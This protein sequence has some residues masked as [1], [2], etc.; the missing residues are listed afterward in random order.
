MSDKLLSGLLS[1][2]PH[3]QAFA[4]TAFTCNT[5]WPDIGIG[6]R[7]WMSVAAMGLGSVCQ[8]LLQTPYRVGFAQ[9]QGR[10]AS[11]DIL[12]MS[13][14][15]QVSRITAGAMGARLR[16]TCLCMADMIQFFVRGHRATGHFPGITMGSPCFIPV[17]LRQPLTICPIAITVQSSKPGPTSFD[18]S[19][20]ID[21]TPK[22][23]FRTQ[24]F[25]SKRRLD[26]RLS[27]FLPTLIMATTK[28][29]CDRMVR[30]ARNGTGTHM[31]L[32]LKPR[33]GYSHGN[34]VGNQGF[35]SDPSRERRA[36]DSPFFCSM[37]AA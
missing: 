35:G 21:F 9:I 18:A 29:M 2:V 34:P 6:W 30:T 10:I 20:A 5:T 11:G 33:D 1:P 3:L 7:Q 12:C 26:K 4:Q 13:H 15:L 23:L 27:I 16:M 36:Y 28:M 37:E 32:P 17:V 25:W 14:R 8:P 31:L 22:S 19:R 24:S